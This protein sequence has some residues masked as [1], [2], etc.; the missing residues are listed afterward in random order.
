MT[1]SAAAH[2]P[3]VK[4]MTCDEDDDEL[5]MNVD[6]NSLQS[7]NNNVKHEPYEHQETNKENQMPKIKRPLSMEKI[8]SSSTSARMMSN[9]VK[10]STANLNLNKK[11]P[12]VE[13]EIIELDDE[14]DDFDF[15]AI[16]QAEKKLTE[17]KVKYQESTPKPLE[18]SSIFSSLKLL[19]KSLI[20]SCCSK[21]TPNDQGQVFVLSSCEHRV[22]VSF[23]HLIGHLQQIKL[24]WYQECMITDS[25]CELHVYLGNDPLCE[26]IELTCHQARELFQ[27][28]R[29]SSNPS[30]TK[31][32]KHFE[33]K[34]KHAE[35][36]I[37]TIKKC[38]VHLKYDLN[39][40]KFCIVKITDYQ[41]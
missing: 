23:S 20:S 1:S 30:E 32:F 12:K 15:E 34:R 25:Q 37:S 35:Y 38:L 13:E 36:K 7:T 33:M 14:E 9:D 31:E 22:Y 3:D 29:E 2:Q 11:K 27:K 18:K 5:L 24:N 8:A 16:R 28:S 6:F 4:N 10:P 21:K 17:N 41:Y 26:L 39:R 19:N 40:S